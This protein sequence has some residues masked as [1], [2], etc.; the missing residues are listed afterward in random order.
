[1]TN[2]CHLALV[3]READLITENRSDFDTPA[4]P[5]DKP[6][7]SRAENAKIYAPS[8]L[9]RLFITS[10]KKTMYLTFNTTKI[11]LSNLIIN[12]TDDKYI[13]RVKNCMKQ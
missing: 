12:A 7:K 6:N 4:R 13:S 5:K 8:K 9:K 10:K 2:I 1:M 11:S 3:I